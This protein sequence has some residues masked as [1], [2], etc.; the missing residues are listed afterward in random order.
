M[1][2]IMA[3]PFERASGSLAER[4]APTAPAPFNADQRPVARL[5]RFLGMGDLSPQAD[6]ITA[7]ANGKRDNIGNWRHLSPRGEI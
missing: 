1:R 2:P 5:E 3:S 4:S 6:S 7:A